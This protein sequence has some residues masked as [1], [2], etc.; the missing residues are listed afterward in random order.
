MLYTRGLDIIE[1]IFYQIATDNTNTED[2]DDATR[3][4]IAGVVDIIQRR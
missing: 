3:V 1:F 4:Q 2:V